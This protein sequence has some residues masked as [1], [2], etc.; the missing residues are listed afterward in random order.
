MTWTKEDKLLLSCCKRSIDDEKRNDIV[1]IQ[2]DIIDWEYFLKK[3][4]SEGISP[5]VFL[6]YGKIITNKEIVPDHVTEELEKD[7]Y[8]NVS[9]N[10]ILL[11]KLGNILHVLNEEG[12]Q[13]IVLKGAALA[14]TVYG[15]IALR[16]MTDVDLL[17]RKEDMLMIDKQLKALGYFPSDR[18][19]GD[20]DFSST[21]LTTLDYR[22]ASTH[23]PSFHIHWHFINSSIPNK[24]YIR[25]IDMEDIWQ[26]AQKTNIADAETLV[27]APHHLLIHLS[28][29]A[30]RISHSF[31]K[32]IFFCDMNEAIHFYNEKLDWDMLMRYSYKFKLDKMVY[33]NL[34]FIS[35]FLEAKIP[36]DLLQELRPKR[37]YFGEEVFLKAVFNNNR[38]PGLSYLVHLSMNKGYFRKMRFIGRTLFPPRH[39]VAQRE[40]M[41]KTSVRWRNYLHRVSE[42]FSHFVKVLFVLAMGFR[43]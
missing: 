42:V 3:A 20:I 32:L 2:R 43:K 28:E 36:G 13:V 27:M 16:P 12:I 11:S 6:E 38:V 8:T 24:H 31:N 35:V 1:E 9:R 40:Y 41:P 17:V 33:F 37:L 18:S 21:Y 39:V 34:Y 15:N 22:H 4:R 5:L 19:I 7:Y 30:L 26:D 23:S 25:D 14:E 10:T 29:H